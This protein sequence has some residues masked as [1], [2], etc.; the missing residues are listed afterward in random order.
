MNYKLIRE[1]LGYN[2]VALEFEIGVLRNEINAIEQG[3]VE[4]PE[5][6][7]ASLYYLLS[8][9]RKNIPLSYEQAENFKSNCSDN[10]SFIRKGI[11]FR[12]FIV[13]FDPKEFDAY[14][15]DFSFTDY[16][17]Y[18]AKQYAYSTR[19]KVSAVGHAATGTTFFDLT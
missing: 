7:K 6:Y 16:N 4:A 12:V 2:Q 18:T 13:P 10:E 17:D 3:K 1:F 14:L 8:Q 9:A 15:R 5:T 11:V 19:Y